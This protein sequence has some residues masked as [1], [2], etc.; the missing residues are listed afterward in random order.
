M[1]GERERKIIITRIGR[2]NA[3]P[4]YWACE[5]IKIIIQ[6]LLLL[7]LYNELKHI[8]DTYNIY[9]GCICMI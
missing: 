2:Y 3:A 7:S 5:N 1:A 9:S 4:H 8:A 6:F